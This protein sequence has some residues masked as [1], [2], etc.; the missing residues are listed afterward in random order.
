MTPTTDQNTLNQTI[1]NQTFV[2]STKNILKSLITVYMFN[3][4]PESLTSHYNRCQ[5]GSMSEC[6]CIRRTYKK[7][8]PET[9]LDSEVHIVN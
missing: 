7:S 3:T 1:R 2:A 6:F 9:C 5:T 8:N 4:H